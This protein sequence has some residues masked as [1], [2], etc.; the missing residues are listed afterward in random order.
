MAIGRALVSELLTDLTACI[1]EAVGRS[2]QFLAIVAVGSGARQ[3]VA[4]RG[5]MATAK[6]ADKKLTHVQRPTRFESG[7]AE[8]NSTC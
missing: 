4:L 3:C 7:G 2:N 1:G 5:A 8:M 6:P